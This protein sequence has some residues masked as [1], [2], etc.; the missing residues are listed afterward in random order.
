MLDFDKNSHRRDYCPTKGASSLALILAWTLAWTLALGGCDARP[1]YYIDGGLQKDADTP[2]PDALTASDAAGDI[3]AGMTLTGCAEQ[4]LTTE[5][6]ICRGTVP[7]S[8]GFASLA[9]PNTTTFKWEFGDETPDADA[10]STSHV[11]RSPGTYTVLLVV[12]GPFGT[13][14]P[15]YVTRVE[16]DPAP[17]GAFCE[18][19]D[20]CT[21][22]LCLC[23]TGDASATDCPPVLQG[24]CAATCPECPEL[25]HCADLS[26]GDATDMGT[27]RRTA[28]LL[29]CTSD[30]DCPRPGFDCREIPGVDP[31][32]GRLWQPTCF[33]DVLA[34]VGRACHNSDDAPDPGLCLSGLC[35]TL[36]RFGLCMEDC[37]ET[38]CPSYATCVSFTGGLHAGQELC[39]ARCSPERPC[40]HD[41]H[42]TCEGPNGA[43]DLGFTL[44]DPAEPPDQTYCAPR[45]CQTT[46]DCPASL[47]DLAA[48][49]FC[50]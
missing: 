27:W 45:R 13:I 2:T 10:P 46:A 12:G 16:V 20:H 4:E 9:P 22:G 8:L 37:S 17:V 41:P 28:C 15:P 3:F 25:T 35:G 43:G 47:C 24:T 36:G 21:D 18:E 38:P 6:L 23:A 44:L 40:S 11:Y 26:I 7:L 30:S 19:D 42:L 5:S 48:G 50:L 32:L 39:V 29:D 33:P 1:R 34:D 49:G 14:S 31:P